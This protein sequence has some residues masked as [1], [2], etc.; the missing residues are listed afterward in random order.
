MQYF[1]IV[2]SKIRID[3]GFVVKFYKDYFGL[4]CSAHRLEKK[5]LEIQVLDKNSIL[6]D[7]LVG[8]VKIDLHTIATGPVY[9]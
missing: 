2:F 3:V 5:S 8:V 7:T 9:I 6:A 4:V 1:F